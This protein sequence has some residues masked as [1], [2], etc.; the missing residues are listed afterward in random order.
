[1]DR[2]DLER[3]SQAS[4]NQRSGRAGRQAPGRTYRLWP[5]Q[6]Q[7][8][9]PPF[10]TPEIHRIDLAPT[11][12]AIH[13]WGNKNPRD[14]PFFEPPTEDRLTA[15]ENLLDL[16]GALQNETL[17]T[18]GRA[19]LRLPLHPRLARLLLAAKNT[20]LEPE[21]LNLATLLSDDS[22]TPGDLLHRAERLP[23]HLTRTHDQLTRILES[24]P[25]IENQ[26]SKIENPSDLLLLA[27]PDRIAKRR[28][29]APDP[30]AA[31]MVNNVGLKLA[32]EA[33][34]PALAR[35]DLF[36]ALDPHHDPRN[37]KAEAT[38]RTAIPIDETSL[39][40][41]FPTHLHTETDLEYDPQKEKVIAI[42]RDYFHDLIL[43]EK[44][45]TANSTPPAPRGAGVPRHRPPPARPSEANSS[46]KTTTPPASSPASPSPAT[47]TP[48]PPGPPSTTPNSTNSS[49]TPAPT[50]APSPT[51]RNPTPSP[52][53]SAPHSPTPST[54]NSTNSPPKPSPSPP[55]T[56]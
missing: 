56:E 43:H 36:L 5:E 52:T 41:L 19:M 1:M 8:H 15:A 12:L 49:A 22:R 25:L 24:T 34:T 23:A 44:I 46:S 26:K 53:P 3:I 32:P 28:A 35:A 30:L 54:A 17:T 51:S 2:L 9:L 6:E 14:F 48:T 31:I 47:T 11:L 55:A 18:L 42:T 10:N 33:L 39:Q 40:R 4:A 21:A 27:Y 50:N 38:V 7:K 37:K 45:L 29:Q 16:L 20:P 13:A